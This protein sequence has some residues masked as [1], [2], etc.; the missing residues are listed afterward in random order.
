MTCELDAVSICLMRHRQCNDR[1]VEVRLAH[2][3]A[4]SIASDG[5]SFEPRLAGRESNAI[6][7]RIL[8]T[9]GPTREYLDPVR[10]L[11]NGSSGRMGAALATEALRRGHEVLVVSGPVQ[12]A[13]P[14]A[15]Q[16]IRVVSTQDM[17]TACLKAFPDCDGVI[18]AAAPCDFQP[19]AVEKHKISKSGDGLTLDL[20]QTPDVI[21]A[22]S[23]LKRK[24]QWTVAYALETQNGLQRATEK[25]RR[26]NCDFIILNDASAIDAANNKVQI[27]DR[28][29][30]ATP[31]QG[32]KDSVAAA[33]L[34]QIELRLMAK[35][36]L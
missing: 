15:A 30:N 2:K 28:N 27:L 35:S 24:D 5:L 7:A 19:R 25:L 11:T 14:E 4:G 23:N 9:S 8:I 22:L 13:Y 31:A 10:Y 17:L 20:V 21:A 12:V 36:G 32:S 26:K 3:E 1:I 18:A 34:D 33:I 6:M 16:V 29:G